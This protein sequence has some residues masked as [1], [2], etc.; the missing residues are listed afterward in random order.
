M[1]LNKYEPNYMK[2][3]RDQVIKPRQRQRTTE[4]QGRTKASQAG[5]YNT[6]AWKQLR[7]AHITEHPLCVECEK[8]HRHVTATLVDHI[9]PV[10]EAPDLALAP[11]N[12]QSLCD[13]HHNQKTKADTRDKKQRQRLANGRRLMQQFESDTPVGG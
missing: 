9:I 10:D 11:S 12:L 5:F 1:K 3:Y 2:M 13:W 6:K 4:K 8:K 7:T